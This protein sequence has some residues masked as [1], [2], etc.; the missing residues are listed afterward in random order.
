MS[1]SIYRP[2]STGCIR[3]LRLK[4]DPD[5]HAPIQ[6]D[7]LECPIL[8]SGR[9]SLYEALSYVWGSGDKPQSI[10]MTP[11]GCNFPVGEN[12]YAALVAL[13]D[14]I[15]ERLIWVD[16]VCINQEDDTEKGHQ[17]QAM[18]KIYARARDVVVWLGPATAG[19]HQAFQLIHGLALDKNEILPRGFSVTPP[20][21]YFA[22]DAVLD[23]VRRAWFKRIWILQEV[24]AARHI[25]IKSG[26]DEMSADAFCAGLAGLHESIEHLNHKD[27][28]VLDP[29]KEIRNSLLRLHPVTR[30]MRHAAFRSRNEN[31]SSPRYS[32]NIA[33]LSEL[34]D[35]YK[36]FEATDPRDKIY[37][38][39]GMSSDNPS[40]AG[41]VP[42]YTICFEEL[43]QRY[44][45]THVSPHAHVTVS[46]D[47]NI[48]VIRARGNVDV[49]ITHRRS[50]ENPQ[51]T[52]D[53]VCRFE[54]AKW[55]TLIR[56]HAD[57][58]ALIQ[59][60]L[61]FDRVYKQSCAIDFLI[62][63]DWSSQFKERGSQNVVSWFQDVGGPKTTGFSLDYPLQVEIRLLSAV[64]IE[65]NMWETLRVPHQNRVLDWVKAAID[66]YHEFLT[67]PAQG[68]TA[69]GKEPERPAAASIEDS[70]FRE[71]GLGE[72][73]RVASL[74]AK[75]TLL[76]HPHLSSDKPW[77]PPS[78]AE[79]ILNPLIFAASNGL[80]CVVQRI[81][82]CDDP[83]LNGLAELRWAVI[84]DN[85]TAI[86]SFAG[87][88]AG[89]RKR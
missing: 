76:S 19:S 34:I 52:L 25:V 32:L 11:D 18:A 69:T 88:A 75:L 46:D 60:S 14:P 41:L 16:A 4:P 13:R 37:A 53:V 57:Y 28:N 79:M 44:I 59:T 71:P 22:K 40:A 2:L 65:Y 17:V 3:L 84:W 23:L 38:L 82:T 27:G 89:A 81:L 58:S 43:I 20:M 42:D 45:N 56:R 74:L 64:M 49:A 67:S 61:G 31:Y 80:V 54:D 35:L 10:S 63:W 55:A 72:G 12:L 48:I 86:R 8:D 21:Q 77:N 85:Q 83:M 33:P 68:S 39:M 24:A 47:K 26:S 70:R 1:T 62:V 36:T 7:L 66:V 30:L 73:D 15:L 78:E 29:D 9:S 87:T 5:D 51:P 6:C 50:L